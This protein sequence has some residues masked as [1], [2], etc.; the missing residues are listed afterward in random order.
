RD[1]MVNSQNQQGHEKGSWYHSG[2]WS[3]RGGRVYDTALST[4]VLEVYYRHMP[5]YKA[6]AAADG[7]P[8]D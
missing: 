1:Q 8:L 7:F 5:I 6:A 2:P 3:E 4:M